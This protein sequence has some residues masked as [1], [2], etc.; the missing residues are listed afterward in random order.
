MA[1]FAFRHKNMATIAP[2]IVSNI[3]QKQIRS[4]SV[5][6]QILKRQTNSV[7]GIRSIRSTAWVGAEADK[8]Q[9]SEKIQEITQKILELTSLEVNQ[10]IFAIQDR[11][12]IPDE[13]LVLG[14]G[15]SSSGG[16]GA[17]PAAAAPEPVKEKEDFGIKLGAVDQKA[18]IKIIKEVRAIT[19]LGLKEAKDLVEKAPVVI[20]D[21]VKKEEAESIKKI[22]VEAGA[23]V[24]LV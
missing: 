5:T 10:L 15:G 1:S 14:G 13:A 19:G 4:H 23:M 22:L 2:S 18:K 6:V 11:L 21:G 9:K 16:S 20:K 8:Y 17:A 12:G 7:V 24:D 3:T